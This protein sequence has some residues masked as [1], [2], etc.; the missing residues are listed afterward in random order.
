MADRVFFGA[1]AFM[2]LLGV[3]FAGCAALWPAPVVSG[4]DAAWASWRTANGSSAAA[5]YVYYADV[6]RCMPE[7]SLGDGVCRVDGGADGVDMPG[8]WSAV[9]V[10]GER[11]FD[12]RA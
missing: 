12:W 5:G 2:S 4:V 1:A 7:A 6:P 11:V 10:D 3:L 9:W 8:G